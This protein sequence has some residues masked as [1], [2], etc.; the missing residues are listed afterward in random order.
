M[1]SCMKQKKKSKR[2]EPT[3][4]RFIW[5]HCF[6]Y[7]ERQWTT[8]AYSPFPCHSPYFMALSYIP[9][10]AS[11]PSWSL[12]NCVIGSC[13]YL[14]SSLLLSPGSSTAL[15][16][17]FLRW[18]DEDCTEHSFCVDQV[19]PWLLE[20]IFLTWTWG[21]HLSKHLILLISYYKSGF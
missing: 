14:W 4:C 1:T 21:L 3:I 11:L 9:S 6:Y 10:I 13:S 19:G 7:W 20:Q 15:P 8:D 5:C 18:E 17:P 16:Y 2:F 12:L